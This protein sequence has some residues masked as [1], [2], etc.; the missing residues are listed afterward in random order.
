M[1]GDGCI[2]SVKFFKKKVGLG[3]VFASN[4]KNHDTRNGKADNLNSYKPAV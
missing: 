3:V 2:P 1:F 4:T